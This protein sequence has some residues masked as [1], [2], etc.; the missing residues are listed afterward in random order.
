MRTRD[1]ISQQY[2]EQVE[3]LMWNPNDT[4]DT[5]KLTPEETDLLWEEIRTEL[6]IGDVWNNI[7]SGLDIVLP[8]DHGPGFFLKGCAAALIIIAGFINVRETIPD[9]NMPDPQIM[10]HTDMTEQSSSLSAGNNYQTSHSPG[11]SRSTGLPLPITEAGAATP[12]PVQVRVRE[13]TIDSDHRML[14]YEVTMSEIPMQLGADPEG[15]HSGTQPLNHPEER[16]DIQPGMSSGITG[17]VEVVSRLKSVSLKSGNESHRGNATLRS[18]EPGRFS[19]GIVT[20]L[21]N[22][23]LLNRETFD[24]LKPE[25]LNT[26]EFVVFPDEGL[27]LSYSFSESWSLNTEAFLCSNTG[28]EY[29]DYI[30]G[31][32]SRKRIVLRY[33]AIALSARYRVSNGFLR[34]SHSSFNLLAGPY[35]SYLISADQKINHYSEGIRSHYTTLDFGVRLGGE[36]EL[37]LNDR[38]SVAPGLVISLGLTNIFR[39]EADIPGYLRNTHNGNAQLQL[40][41]YYHYD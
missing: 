37:R 28:Q 26:T 36:L 5:E 9:E 33:S 27:L 14:A 7:S 15:T 30:F 19:G 2:R 35:L 4:G 25:S 20:S 38:L 41:F 24:G 32:Y 40:S 23:W 16:V 34:E 1:R 21:K 31:K 3:R 17:N 29:L 12:P 11:D 8:P 22:T 13:K 6:D 18:A 10:P 39:G